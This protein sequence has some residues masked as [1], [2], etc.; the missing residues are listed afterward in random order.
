MDS[1]QNGR[2]SNIQQ[3]QLFNNQATQLPIDIVIALHASRT[4]MVEEGESPC[5]ILLRSKDGIEIFPIPRK[6]EEKI[7]KAQDREFLLE[8]PSTLQHFS[9]DGSCVFVHQPSHGVVKCPL[10]GSPS[11]ERVKEPFLKDSQA[12]QMLC[13]SPKGTYILTWE[14][15]SAAD[16]QQQE[17]APNLKVWDGNTGAFLHGF[18]Q[19]SLKRES[20]PYLQWTHDEKYAFLNTTNEIRVF[21]GNA[22][23]NTDSEVRFH[24]KMKCQVFRQYKPA[25]ASLHKYPSPCPPQAASYPAVVS[26][27]LFQAEEINVHWA[28]TGDAALIALQT[29]VDTS[30]KSYYGSTTLH[31]MTE[32]SKEVITVPLP[33]NTTGPVLDVAWMPNATKPPCFAVV[34]GTMPAMASLHNGITADATFLFGNAHRNTICWAPHGRFVNIAGF[35]NLAGGM[36][37]WDRNKLKVIPQYDAATGI[38]SY[39]EVMA[40]CTVGYGWSSDSRSFFSST[41]SPRMNVDNGVKLFHYNGEEVHN[42]PWD[43]AN[44]K[45]NKLLQ[46]AFVPAPPNVYSDRPQSPAPRISGDAVAIA[47]AK[48]LAT[49]AATN[50]AAATSTTQRYVP[51]SAR[52]R[53]TGGVGGAMS[54]AD[55]IRLEKEGTIMA[56]TK[57]TPRLGLNSATNNGK[58]VPVGMAPPPPEGKSKTALRREKQKLQK[59][60]EE[61]EEAKAKA[62]EEA[63]AAAAIAA[64]NA[65]ADPEKRAKK[66]NKILR[67]IEELKTKDESTW[68]D[69]QK[70]KVASEPELLAEL[71]TLQL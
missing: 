42:V 61:E 33:N 17:Q 51:P 50:P 55:K 46:A 64:A 31:L 63:A 14:R 54:L 16:P 70:R 22:F 30:G 1:R 69:D 71:A 12:I 11:T 43:N 32:A 9:P 5:R 38:P 41:T 65:K 24:D 39:R 4:T 10:D 59:L 60:K 68:N 23:S 47:E 18:I 28:P 19:K 2:P 7:D 40:S 48:K 44:Y 62:K 45:P 21:D 36:T 56:A 52:G 58:H 25:R 37:F 53:A 34:S 49:Q 13:T 66:I 57:V 20:W 27:S 67:Q 3:F 6:G 26:K 35:G 15:L 29:S 8:G